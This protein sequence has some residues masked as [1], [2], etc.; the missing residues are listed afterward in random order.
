L[1]QKSNPKHKQQNLANN[2][3]NQLE[4]NYA[5]FLLMYLTLF[6]SSDGHQYEEKFKWVKFL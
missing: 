4:F 1:L 5:L 6:I 3:E 2:K